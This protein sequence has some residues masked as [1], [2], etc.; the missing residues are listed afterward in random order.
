MCHLQSSLTG[1]SKGSL[2]M[3]LLLEFKPVELYVESI[4]Q[5][6]WDVAAVCADLLYLACAVCPMALSLL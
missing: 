1:A 4:E 2:G 5:R 3:D 6:F